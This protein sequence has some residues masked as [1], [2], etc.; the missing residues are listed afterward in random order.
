M[1]SATKLECSG[2]FKD[3]REMIV[4]LDNAGIFRLISM[5]ASSVFI[6]H[7]PFLPYSLPP[8]LLSYHVYQ[9]LF[10]QY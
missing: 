10:L 7:M 6:S 1:T 2:R 4:A 5:L 3:E 9:K 8:T